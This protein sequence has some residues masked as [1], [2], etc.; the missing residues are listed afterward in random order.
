MENIKMTK[1]Y[2]YEIRES[3]STDSDGNSYHVKDLIAKNDNQVEKWLR[4][5]YN[6][7]NSDSS[8]SDDTHIIYDYSAY[9]LCD[10]SELIEFKGECLNCQEDNC[11]K[12]FWRSDMI[13]ATRSEKPL[14][15]HEYEYLKSGK[16][17]CSVIDI[18]E[19]N[20]KK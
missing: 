20:I 8:M 18:S 5:N 15:N 17:Y 4:D 7:E 13:E 11:D 12:H 16:H 19:E 3:W 9:Y 14:N 1:L 10:T 6:L 2:S